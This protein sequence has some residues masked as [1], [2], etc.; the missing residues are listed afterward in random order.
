[1]S[2]LTAVS[3]LDVLKASQAAA[4]FG[5]GSFAYLSSKEEKKFY[6][7]QARV[8]MAEAEADIENYKREAEDFKKKQ[9]VQ[10]LKSG[11]QISGTV[12]DVLDETVL[13]SRERISAMR[14]AA[15][16]KALEYKMEGRRSRAIGRSKLLSGM[17][18]AITPFVK[19]NIKNTPGAVTE[20]DFALKGGGGK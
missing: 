17:V 11:V 13:V 9:M 1:M 6:D 14:S 16:S 5:A 19:Y 18:D 7:S 2:G 3:T 4:S 20:K 12:L 15:R 10:Y 8:M